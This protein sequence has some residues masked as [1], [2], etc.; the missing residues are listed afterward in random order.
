MCQNFFYKELCT[1]YTGQWGEKK[2]WCRCTIMLYLRPLSST[3][4]LKPTIIAYNR[5]CICVRFNDGML[6]T[7]CNNWAKL[8][9]F[10]EVPTKCKTKKKSKAPFLSVQLNKFCNFWHL[11]L[12][13]TIFVI[14]LRFCLLPRSHTASCA[15]F[16]P[17]IWSVFPHL[18]YTLSNTLSRQNI[19]FFHYILRLHVNGTRCRVQSLRHF[20]LHCVIPFSFTNLNEINWLIGRNPIY[21]QEINYPSTKR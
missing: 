13:Q 16:S 10:G 2:I 15:V 5:D 6:P 4:Q 18:P 14:N 1:S 3:Q 19:S 8:Y 17:L 11:T 7:I 12:Q 21:L 9:T 20:L